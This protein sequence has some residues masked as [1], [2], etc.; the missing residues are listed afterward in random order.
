VLKKLSLCFLAVLP[1]TLFGSLS[2]NDYL[3]QE[4]FNELNESVVIPIAGDILKDKWEFAF[5]DQGQDN[6]FVLEFVPK[7]EKI[8]NWSQLLQVQYFPLVKDMK[9]KINAQI[10]AEH[11]LKALKTH[12]PTVSIETIKSEA[13]NVQV[14][15]KL[16]S[17]VGDEK[18]QD[19]IATIISTDS[20]LF[21]AAYT[22]KVPDMPSEDR[23]NWIDI[24]SKIE[25]K[26][27]N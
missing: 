3:K 7:G 26:N 24:L 9:G 25:I 15:W 14:E 19:E 13:N 18:P 16:P 2:T 27:S 1:L 22:Q 4:G 17:K 8:D 5:S 11:F 23:A 20:S 12:F 10:F 6:S 21:R